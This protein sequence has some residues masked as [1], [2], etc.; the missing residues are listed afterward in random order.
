MKILVIGGAGGIGRALV[1]VFLDHYKDADILATFHSGR[2]S[3][4]H[5]RLTWHRVDITQED[6]IKALAQDSGSLNILVNAVGFLHG[7]DQQQPQN[8]EKSIQHFT[9]ELLQKNLLLN[10][11]P[12]LL[13]AK[14]F[15]SNLRASKDSYFVSLSARVGSLSDNR[16]GGW[17]SYRASKA[18]LNMAVKTIALEWKTKLPHCC[19]LLFH[20]GT[21]DT[22]LSQPFQKNLPEGQVHSPDY[23]AKALLALLET[24]TPNDSGRF[25]SYDGSDIPW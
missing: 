4:E 9:P 18:A 10:T 15:M 2:A 17:I 24:L 3:F 16:V 20:P 13:L 8:P 21:T 6:E 19:V 23:T 11:Q 22:P 5:P 7:Q 14:H 12:S 1:D 25:C